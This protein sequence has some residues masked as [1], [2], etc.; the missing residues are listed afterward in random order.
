MERCKIYHFSSNPSLSSKSIYSQRSFFKCNNKR[1]NQAFYTLSWHFSIF[2]VVVPA[3]WSH[4]W[5]LYNGTKDTEALP[6]ARRR[7]WG[8]FTIFNKLFKSFLLTIRKHMQ[9][10]SNHYSNHDINAQIHFKN[11]NSSDM[12]KLIFLSKYRKYIKPLTW[13]RSPAGRGKGP[14]LPSL[15]HITLYTVKNIYTDPM[16]RAWAFL[17]FHGMLWANILSC[18]CHTIHSQDVL[19]ASLWKLAFCG[20]SMR[21]DKSGKIWVSERTLRMNVL[22]IES[23]N[24]SCCLSN[25]LKILN[26]NLH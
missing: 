20:R 9:G 7:N 24:W 1:L 16:L 21:E 8:I 13:K 5:L 14:F 19:W 18:V 2:L 22:D 6:R 26:I 15:Y 3:V 12:V 10:N 23:K 11:Y 25:E 4:P 17:Y